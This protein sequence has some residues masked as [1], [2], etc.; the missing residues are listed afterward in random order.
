MTKVSLF[1]G[2]FAEKY[3]FVV[4][5]VGSCLLIGIEKHYESHMTSRW[6]VQLEKS[7]V[8]LGRGY[9]MEK[10]RLLPVAA[11]VLVV[12]LHKSFCF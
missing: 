10:W 8:Y 9:L 5:D 11:L 7:P 12:Q 2:Q 1:F 3:G 6:R 4:C